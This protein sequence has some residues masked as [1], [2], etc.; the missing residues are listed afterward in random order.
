MNIGADHPIGADRGAGGGQVAPGDGG[1]PPT[2][3]IAAIEARRRGGPVARRSRHQ[4][5]YEPGN[6]WIWFCEVVMFSMTRLL[7]RRHY[8]GMANVAVPGAVL[9]VSN[10]ISHIDPVYDAVYIRKTGRIPHILAKASLWKLPVLGGALR[11][12]GQIPVERGGGQGQV[13]L[14]QA[15]TA[16]QEGRVVLI[17]PEGTVTRDPDL[18]PMRPRPGVAALALSGDFPVVP[19]AQWGTHRVYR[20]YVKKGFTPLPR[21]DITVVAG[22]PIDLSAYRN[23][24]V[25][26]RA[27]RDVSYVIMEAVR[28]LLATLRPEDPPQRF[29]D[30]KL[31]DRLAKSETGDGRSE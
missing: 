31:A 5:V 10:H 14:E 17:Y 23:G 4:P 3:L 15:V 25:D 13:G 16:L 6:V 22:P 30:P 19:M 28:D 26:A 8:E 20:S 1:P 11:G 9:V 7:G 2:R 24:P 18:W 21:Q 29:F 27:I 12:T